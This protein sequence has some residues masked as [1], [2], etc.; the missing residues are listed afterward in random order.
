VKYRQ[1]TIG[2]NNRGVRFRDEKDGTAIAVKNQAE[3]H[4]GDI[5]FSRID[6]RNGAIG[7]VPDDLHGAVVA[8]D[9]PVYELGNLM[10]TEFAV[11]AFAPPAFRQQAIARSAGSTNRKK[12]R[13]ESF[14]QLRIPAPKI[15]EQRIILARLAAL[16]AKATPVAGCAE[17]LVADMQQL[18]AQIANEMLVE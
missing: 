11:A 7:V 16:R 8:N 6:I 9:F 5:V 17:R 15:D 4:A 3:V 13:R 14:L 12:M 2:M 10:L 1:L 18:R